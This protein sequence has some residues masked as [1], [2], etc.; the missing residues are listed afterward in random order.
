MANSTEAKN[1]VRELQ[2]G[3]TESPYTSRSDNT[4]NDID[5]HLIKPDLSRWLAA[6]Q[7]YRMVDWC[8]QNNVGMIFAATT[9]I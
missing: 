6:W 4:S 8:T 5:L 1:K 3:S 9:Y 2:T 7:T